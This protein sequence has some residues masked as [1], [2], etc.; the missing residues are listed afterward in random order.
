MADLHQVLQGRM[1]PD[2]M[3]IGASV[4]NAMSEE[5]DTKHGSDL[6]DIE[7]VESDGDRH[8]IGNYPFPLS[9]GFRVGLYG[10]D[11]MHPTDVGYALMAN[12]II[13]QLDPGHARLVS[14]QTM[15]GIDSLLRDPPQ[16]PIDMRLLLSL[17][18]AFGLL[19]GGVGVMAGS[20]M[21]EVLLPT[22][23]PAPC[24]RGFGAGSA[25]GNARKRL[26]IIG[27]DRAEPDESFAPIGA[28]PLP[29]PPPTRGGGIYSEANVS[30]E[31]S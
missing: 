30:L 28:R 19:G 1:G 16:I 21:S 29:Q 11:N 26:K 27:P 14:K 25:R 31:D 22:Y 17:V 18:G 4:F 23:S 15:A 20:M 5:R 6:G 12:P 13:K 2:V 10:L 8:H 7:Y 9:S 24:G 3:A